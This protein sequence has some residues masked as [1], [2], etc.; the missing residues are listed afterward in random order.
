MGGRARE[1]PRGGDLLAVAAEFL[2]RKA[3]ARYL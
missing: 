3:P 1:N 2:Y